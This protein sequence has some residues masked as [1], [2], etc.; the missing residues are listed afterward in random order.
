MGLELQVGLTKQDFVPRTQAFH[1]EKALFLYLDSLISQ[2]ALSEE[3]ISCHCLESLRAI[4]QQ[5]NFRDSHSIA[6]FTR[7]L[8]TVVGGYVAAFSEAALSYM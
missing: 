2:T 5:K 6:V 7:E 8:Q 1:K 3:I 4:L